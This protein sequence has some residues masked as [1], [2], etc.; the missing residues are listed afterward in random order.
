MFIGSIII[1]TLTIIFLVLAVLFKPSIKIGK[2]QLQTF[3][4]VSLIGGLLLIFFRMIPLSE[5]F[6]ILTANSSVNPLKILV[7]FISISF[8][9]IVLDELGFFNYISVKAI[10]YVKNNQYALFF[11]I[12]FLV[13]ILTIF[14]SND[15]VILTF[16]P[17]ICYFAK[18]G[19]INPIPYLVMEFINANTYSMLFSIGN[20]TNIYLSSSFNISF[21]TYFIKMSLPTLFAGVSSL[22]LL[23]LL[24]KKQLSKPID[25]ITIEQIPLKNKKLIIINLIHLACATILLAISNYINLPMWIISLLCASSLLVFVIIHTIKEQDSLIKYSIKRL[26]FNLI[27]FLLSMFTIVSVLN[28]QGVIEKIAVILNKFSTNVYSTSFTYLLSS[29]LTCNLIN[30]IPMTIFYSN[31]IQIAN[32]LYLDNAIYAT[33]IGSNIGAYLTPIGAL[34]GIMWMSILKNQDIKY[35]FI[36][37]ILYGITIVPIVMF[38]SYLGL[39]II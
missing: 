17:F 2:I 32:P 33:I 34:A 9:S 7:L 10:N 30:N 21:I 20:P 12:Y 35:N 19:K 29:L 26:P 39:I 23:V 22:I 11:I 31:I 6:N 8:L 4:I 24:F 27:P 5:L 18:K 37:F 1:S 3:W 14:T 36:S 16:T 13:A 28:Y 38:F 15:I 25:D